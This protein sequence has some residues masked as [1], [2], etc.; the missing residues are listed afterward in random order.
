MKKLH[1]VLFFVSSLALST[2]AHAQSRDM[3]LRTKGYVNPQE[4]VS[5]DSTMRMDQALLV[6][7]ELSKQFAGKIIIDTEKRKT[8]IGVYV[9]NQHWRDALDM[10]LSRNGLT[11]DEEPEYIRIVPAGAAVQSAKGQENVGEPPP[12]LGSRD[13]KI[14]AVFFSTNLDKLQTYGVSW[15]FFRSKSK[16]PALQFFNSAGLVRGDTTT[17]LTGADR[18]IA[19]PFSQAPP[20]SKALGVLSSPPEFTFANIDAIVKF[21]GHDQLGEVIT[22]P[23]ITVRNG[24]KGRIQ[25]GKNIFVTTRDISGNSISQQVQTGTIIDVTPTIYTQSDTNFIYLDLTIEQSDAQVGT[26]GP[27]IAKSQVVTHALLYDGEETAIGGLYTTVEQQ[28]REGVPFLKDLPWWFFGLRYLFGSD[29]QTK[30]RNELIVLLKAELSSPIRDRMTTHQTQ[31]EILNNRRK[32]L[33]QD[34]QK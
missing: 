27:E 26:T 6:L 8:P 18:I 33:Q 3:R 16:E 13:V 25:V 22:S 21:F 34:F 23:D 24:K 4:I 28:V 11:Y 15:D 31:Q 30:Q 29:N 32:Q 5:L 14:S 19:P 9:V 20:L 12:T 7:G 10:I 2:F 17:Q 1:I